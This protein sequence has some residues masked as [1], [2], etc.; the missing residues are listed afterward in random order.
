MPG[1]LLS[2]PTLYVS[3]P[4]LWGSPPPENV[5]CAKARDKAPSSACCVVV[6]LKS[7]RN[8]RNGSPRLPFTLLLPVARG[9]AGGGYFAEAVS[10]ECSLR[11]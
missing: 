3:S 2:L 11:G 8:S 7:S 5:F 10:E 1:Q 9:Q 4:L 6:C